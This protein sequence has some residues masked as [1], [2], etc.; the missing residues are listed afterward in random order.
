M[1]PKINALLPVSQ[2]HVQDGRKEALDS[3][4]KT[5]EKRL[6][7]DGDGGVYALDC[8]MVSLYLLFHHY[9]FVDFFNLFFIPQLSA[10]TQYRSSPKM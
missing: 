9:V 3:Y 8:E 2:Q 4:V 1:T 7:V 5:F 10:Y 6:P